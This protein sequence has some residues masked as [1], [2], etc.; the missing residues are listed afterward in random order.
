MT[1]I[2]FPI[3]QLRN[4]ESHIMKTFTSILS[5]L[6]LLVVTS[7]KK[8]IPKPYNIEVESQED[9]DLICSLVENGIYDGRITFSNELE[10]D[11]SCFSQITEVTESVVLRCNDCI[12]HLENLERV[13]KEGLFFCDLAI[14]DIHFPKLRF[15][16]GGVGCF[17]DCNHI[18]SVNLPVLE[19]AFWVN[20]NANTESK[21]QSFTGCNLFRECAEISIISEQDDFVLD[22]FRSL[23]SA[24]NISLSIR[25]D[26]LDIK[27]GAFSNLRKGYRIWI[28]SEKNPNFNFNAFQNLM[29]CDNLTA[30]GD[31]KPNDLCP[32]VPLL[33]S[34][35][36]TNASF[37]SIEIEDLIN[38]CE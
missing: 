27:D 10:L 38:I 35:V 1:S 12:R 14:E 4:I 23:E 19:E 22:G 11:Y 8:K 30:V 24:N 9:V 21:L 6:L 34:E 2:I 31:F 33:K 36:V 20:F 5:L 29:E 13:G 32:L 26:N 3:F 7:C 25:G 15:A 37:S 28:L 16:A 17:T 18:K